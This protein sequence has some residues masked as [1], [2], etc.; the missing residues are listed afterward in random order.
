MGVLE[1]TM[2][3]KL[4]LN[5]YLCL[6]SAR[7]KSMRHQAGPGSRI[8]IESEIDKYSPLFQL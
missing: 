6:H 5:S 3:T 1:L 2:S 7:I 4:A 8:F